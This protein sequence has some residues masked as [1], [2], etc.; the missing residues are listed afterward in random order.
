MG[1]IL[2]VF[3]LLSCV[4]VVCGICRAEDEKNPTIV[5]PATANPPTVDGI[6]AADEWAGAAAVSGF[7]NPQGA[8]LTPP[9]GEVYMMHDWENIYFAFR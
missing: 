4:I 6:I 1:K 2:A 8:L 5:V 7:M 3:A 9:G